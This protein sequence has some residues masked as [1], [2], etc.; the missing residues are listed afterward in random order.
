MVNSDEVAKKVHEAIEKGKTRSSLFVVLSHNRHKNPEE[1]GKYHKKSACEHGKE[2]QVLQI[3]KVLVKLVAD[4]VRSQKLQNDALPRA[5]WSS[6]A[7][8]TR[9]KNW[10]PKIN[11]TT[12]LSASTLLNSPQ[13][14]PKLLK[15]VD[16]RVLREILNVGS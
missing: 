7:R 2:D 14:K 9:S 15:G 11:H 4:T 12:V 1:K 5:Y 8:S 13:R 3:R 16:L 10:Q 6:V